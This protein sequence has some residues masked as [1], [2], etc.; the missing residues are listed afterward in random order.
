[1]ARAAFYGSRHARIRGRS[2]SDAAAQACARSDRRKICLAP[3]HRIVRNQFTR[4]L[5]SAPIEL[6]CRLGRSLAP[7]SPRTNPALFRRGHIASSSAEKFDRPNTIQRQSH[8]FDESPIAHLHNHKNPR[9]LGDSLKCRFWEGIER[10]RPE[11]AHLNTV[12]ARLS[13]DSLQNATDDPVT[14]QHDFS[15][16]DCHSS[17]RASS[18]S[19]H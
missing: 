5:P 15:I 8:I 10:D 2:G 14:N 16:L 6:F 13:G 7:A 4:H 9:T 19:A 11:N 17:A 12:C 18:C 1:M 3:H